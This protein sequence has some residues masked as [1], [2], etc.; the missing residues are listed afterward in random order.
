MRYILAVPAVV[1]ALLLVG[2]CGQPV[3]EPA[4]LDISLAAYL[5]KGTQ[6][7]EVQ[8]SANRERAIVE[9]IHF[10]NN[11]GEYTS[12]C[13][14]LDLKKGTVTPLADLLPKGQEFVYGQHV[15]LSP[16]GRYLAVLLG[17]HD[18]KAKVDLLDVGAKEFGH[19]RF[20]EFAWRGIGGVTWAGKRLLLYGAQTEHV[21]AYD[22]KTD[23]R[24][25]LPIRGTVD[26]AD[27]SGTRLMLNESAIVTLQG[28]MLREID[29]QTCPLTPEFS[30]NGK[31][32]AFFRDCDGKCSIRLISVDSGQTQD[33]QDFGG[34]LGVTDS[35][36]PVANGDKGIA[37]WKDGWKIIAPPFAPTAYTTMAQV[38]GEE[39]FYVD[40]ASLAFK[41]TRLK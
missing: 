13:L 41:S 11:R 28:K 1:A 2:G 34:H 10:V 36:S 39:L 9:G 19:V 32:V 21:L 40:N 14:V 25:T 16:D 26:R 12:Q 35:G 22:P 20:L 8:I 24:E 7:R 38:C 31:Y 29:G 5:P 6:I 17:D 30:S 18:G 23:K 3:T 27:A 37:I 4:P 15:S 33:L